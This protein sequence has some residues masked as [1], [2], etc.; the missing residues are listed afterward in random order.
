[1]K[2]IICYIIIFVL[3]M[4]LIVN[5][6]VCD[7][8]KVKIKSID[9][10]DKS[11]GVVE[12]EEATI[13][14]LQVGLNLKFSTQGDFIE[15]KIIVKNEGNEDFE[16]SKNDIKSDYFD[17]YYIYVDNTPIIKANSEKQIRFRIDYSHPVSSELINNGFSEEKQIVLKLSND[18][19]I[20]NP[21]TSRSTVF[22]LILI[23]LGFSTII[24]VTKN[25]ESAP[26]LLFILLLLPTGVFALCNISI[27]TNSKI[28]VEKVEKEF[29]YD[30][31]P[32]ISEFSNP[33]Y[34]SYMDG[35][36]WAEYFSSKY[37]LINDSTSTYR[38]Y[39]GS[40]L[41]EECPSCKHRIPNQLLR[42]VSYCDED[43]YDCIDSESDVYDNDKILDK[44]I[45]CYT[46]ELSY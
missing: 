16:L 41:S 6:E 34:Y 9:L 35:M 21:K 29:C 1:M 2:R 22:G 8:S 11:D 36:T 38:Y 18:K 46:T 40:S 30:V 3:F 28:V 45:G 33:E 10:M 42:K 15:Y 13:K 17:Y 4:P 31:S 37:N 7:T 24:F 14:D 20:T 27:A 39:F 26:I 19:N 25:K 44:S 43:D 23:L 5:A 12:K 32:Q